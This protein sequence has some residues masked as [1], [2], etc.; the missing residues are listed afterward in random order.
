MYPYSS[1]HSH[2]WLETIESQAYELERNMYNKIKNKVS[3][4]EKARSHPAKPQPPPP[5]DDI[6]SLKEKAELAVEYGNFLVEMRHSTLDALDPTLKFRLFQLKSEKSWGTRELLGILVREYATARDH[7][8]VRDSQ[9]PSVRSLLSIGGGQDYGDDDPYLQALRQKEGEL[10]RNYDEAWNSRAQ[11]MERRHKLAIQTKNKELDRVERELN[12]SWGSSLEALKVQHHRDKK[13]ELDDLNARWVTHVDE[14][15]VDHSVALQS[16]DGELATIEDRVNQRWQQTI[17]ELN[18]LIDQLKKEMSTAEHKHVQDLH[19][20]D[21]HHKYEYDLLAAAKVSGEAAHETELQTQQT[22][23]EGQLRQQKRNHIDKVQKLKDDHLEKQTQLETR[24]AAERDRL[25]DTIK[26]LKKQHADDL[27]EL[28]LTHARE[29]G[30]IDDEHEAV[31]TQ[32]KTQRDQIEKKTKLE[33]Q[34]DVKRLKQEWQDD[35]KGLKQNIESVN[36]ILFARER[37]TP[38]PDR[39]LGEKFSSLVHDVQNLARQT[40][41]SDQLVWSDS[42]MRSVTKNPPR[43]REQLLQ[44]GIWWILHDCVFCSPF[45]MFGDEGRLLEERWNTACGRGKTISIFEHVN[46]CA[47]GNR[48]RIADRRIHLAKAGTGDRALAMGSSQA[49]SNSPERTCLT[50]RPSSSDK[51]RF[52]GVSRQSDQNT[53]SSCERSC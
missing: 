39:V 50:S 19:T 21:G 22:N 37:F 10:K 11:E 13:A 8:K 4:R 48:L 43:L 14:L 15:K 18:F 27:S 2:S 12:H 26:D 29:I 25:K 45:R 20:K 35:V 24:S 32:L 5:V 30:K 34:E 23:Y 52:Q 31:V 42:V 9:W 46:S 33:W 44:D 38:M 40:W 3:A 7:L 17:N 51:E 41:R 47:D 16:K 1:R 6:E 36:K 49:V 28:K 53:P